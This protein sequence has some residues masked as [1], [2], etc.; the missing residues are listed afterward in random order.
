MDSHESQPP[1]DLSTVA[2]DEE[3]KRGLMEDLKRLAR[4][5]NFYRRVEK[6]WKHEYLL[7]ELPKTSKSSLVAAMASFLGFN[8]YD[9]S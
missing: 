6:A 4:R 8:A 3:A 9:W 7:Y 5:K 2:M 1:R